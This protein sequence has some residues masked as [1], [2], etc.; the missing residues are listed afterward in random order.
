MIRRLVASRSATQ[1]RLSRLDPAF[2]AEMVRVCVPEANDS[3]VARVQSAADGIPFLVEEVLASPG[4]PVSFSDTVRARMSNFPEDERVVL[5]TAAIFGRQFDWQLVSDVVGHMPDV[6]T[7]TDVV[8]S[9]LER[10]VKH[11]LLVVESGVFFFRHA[12]TRVK[13]LVG[14]D[15]C[16]ISHQAIVVSGRLRLKTDNGDEQE[17]WPRCRNTRSD[18]MT[19]RSPASTS[20]TS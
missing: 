12:L 4:V 14:T 9:A 16:Q 18:H 10:G 20:W 2:V 11:Q 8:V 19:T 17:W 1:V 13:P 6:V 5:S 3:T 15:S 7:G